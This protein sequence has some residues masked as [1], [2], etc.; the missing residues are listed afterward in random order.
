VKAIGLKTI[1]ERAE[2]RSNSLMVLGHHALTKRV[3]RL[4][5][6]SRWKLGEVA[7]GVASIP[8]SY[9]AIVSAAERL[10]SNPSLG[11]FGV[12]SLSTML[13]MQGIK[14]L[15]Q[16]VPGYVR[17][18]IDYRISKRALKGIPRTESLTY[19]DSQS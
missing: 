19:I 5:S 15:S 16:S 8:L 1:L 4:C 14:I 2:S 12:L 13:Y 17:A 3:E 10:S 9:V 7:V 6:E 18:E 11:N